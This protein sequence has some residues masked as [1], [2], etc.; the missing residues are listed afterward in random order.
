MQDSLRHAGQARWAR[1]GS[2]CPPTQEPAMLLAYGPCDVAP[3]GAPAGCIN[4]HA[5][6]LRGLD[7]ATPARDRSSAAGHPQAA[8]PGRGRS[9]LARPVE[10]RRVARR[11][12]LRARPHAQGSLEA[13]RSTDL[14]SRKAAWKPSDPPTS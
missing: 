2:T 12:K 4:A 1:A 6:E 8:T 9:A 11:S 5:R 3:G 10:S 7:H 14:R 13:V